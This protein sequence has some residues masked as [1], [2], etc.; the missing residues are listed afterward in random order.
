MG[1]L[2]GG[3]YNDILGFTLEP[4]TY[5]NIHKGTIVGDG[6]GVAPEAAVFFGLK[7]LGWPDA[8]RKKVL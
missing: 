1:S 8:L 5:G 4:P 7:G 6:I 2:F 3:L